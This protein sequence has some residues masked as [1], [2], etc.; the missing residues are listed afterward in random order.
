MVKTDPETLIL[1]IRRSDAVFG[2]GLPLCWDREKGNEGYHSIEWEKT[3]DGF[4]VK[5]KDY[6]HPNTHSEQAGIF[7]PEIYEMTP[8]NWYWAKEP[9]A[10]FPGAHGFHMKRGLA[11]KLNELLDDKTFSGLGVYEELHRK[12]IIIGFA[13]FDA[14]QS[15]R[16][17][18]YDTLEVSADKLLRTYLTNGSRGSRNEAKQVVEWLRYMTTTEH[19]DEQANIRFVLIHSMSDKEIARWCLF[20]GPD[21]ERYDREAETGLV[22]RT[23]DGERIIVPE[24]KMFASPENVK[25][26]LGTLRESLTQ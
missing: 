22:K 4:R 14:I 21:Y 8:D 5:E 13:T 23:D 20:M 26:A 7:L 16:S 12:N 19:Q 2:F 10:L 15:R 6:L 11:D 24:S 1:G 25:R 9:V 17:Q 18:W 3:D